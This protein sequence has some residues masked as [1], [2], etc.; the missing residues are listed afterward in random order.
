MN[1]N[2]ASNPFRNRALPWTVTAIVTLFSV[3]ALIF[4]AKWTFDANAKGQVYARE[5]ATLREK[6]NAMNKRAEEIK[7]ALTPDQQRSLKTAHTLVNRK[8]FSWSLLFAELEAALPDT[9]KVTRI[10]VKGVGVPDDRTV[11]L[12]L[13]VASKTS[14]NVTQL[15][16]KM[17]REGVFYAGLVSRTSSAVEVTGARI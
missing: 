7:I 10:A 6:V 8:R 4:I 14:A 16:E 15:I 1:L 11:D 17:E 3:V 5:A 12:E 2:L 13:V 9:I